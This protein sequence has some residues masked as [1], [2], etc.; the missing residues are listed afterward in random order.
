[1]VSPSLLSPYGFASSWPRLQRV[2]DTRY[3]R[4]ALP[5]TAPIVRCVPLDACMAHG[6]AFMFYLRTFAN[7]SPHGAQHGG[8]V[9]NTPA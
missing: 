4:R 5:V 7:A 3:V 1:M 8:R 9:S 2:R 6:S